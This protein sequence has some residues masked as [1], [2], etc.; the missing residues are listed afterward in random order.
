MEL[1]RK[2]I[3]VILVVA[4]IIVPIVAYAYI[5]YGPSSLDELRIDSVVP[6]YEKRDGVRVIATA[7][8]SGQDFEGSVDL[9]VKFEKE[10]VYTGKASFQEGYLNHKL[11]FEDF[12]KGNGEY[13][14]HIQYEDFKDDFTF[15]LDIV[16]EEMGV[17][18]A[19]SHGVEGSGTQPWE[20]SYVY[21]VVFT[22]GWHLFS[23]KI[24]RNEFASYDLGTRF[25]G[26]SAPLRVETG[27]EYGCK[28]EVYFT[29]Q[30]GVQ[31]RIHT[32]D[33]PAGDSLVTTIDF[34]QNGSYLY[35]YIN[36][37]TVDI[38]IDAYENRPIDKLP[39]GGS[40]TLTQRLGS[41]TPYE[42][43]RLMTAI[44]QISGT[45]RPQSGPGNY[46][47][48]IEYPNTQVMAGLDLS[49]LTFSEVI[50]LNDKLNPTQISTLQRTVKFS[51]LDSFDDGSKQDLHVYWS[52]GANSE[53]TIAAVDG[54]WEIY[55]EWEFTYP[56]GENPDVTT[57][58]PFL[59]LMDAY[60]VESEIY[61]IN[62][63]VA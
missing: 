33:V 8:A 1:N 7:I 14:F 37:M 4:I 22:T 51:A 11:F 52:A 18:T 54:P 61:Y 40:I 58:K 5:V 19:A 50:E 2:L 59:L 26:E 35:K 15:E 10:Q 36:E 30:G 45:L 31:S 9:Q 23:H 41:G 49:T 39:T 32:F 20:V 53:G 47:M 24:A 56:L 3:T 34:N 28:V 46:T 27:P 21:H 13:E 44:D 55:K 42:E 38:E 63:G 62:L 16:A 60:G 17:V 6:D 43:N 57:G 48:T 25:V 12:C 29:N